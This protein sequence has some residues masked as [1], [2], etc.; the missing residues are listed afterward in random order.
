MK[1]IS[2]FLVCVLLSVAGPV[3]AKDDDAD[4]EGA[5]G[6][7]KYKPAPGSE[8]KEQDLV[9]PSYPQEDDLVQID[10]DRHDYP[11]TL[12]VDT[13]SLSVG[14][15]DII[16]YTAI[17][18]SKAGVDNISFEGI[19]CIRHQYKRYAYGTGG[20]FYPVPNA[21][22]RRI[23]KR[24]QDTY[25]NVL[26]DDYFCPLPTGNPVPQLINRLKGRGAPHLLP[27]DQ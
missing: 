18:R 21:D 11:Y 26:A 13:R 8:W 20:Q 3:S 23:Q 27:S 9:I 25:R 6:N 17:L 10:I 12:F 5:L 14:K 2:L 19:L 24:R 4:N 16:R 1:I 15:D 7:L 22:W